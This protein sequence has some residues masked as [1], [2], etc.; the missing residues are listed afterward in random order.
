MTDTIFLV[1]IFAALLHA[2]WNALVKGSQDK[3][4][5]MMGVSLGDLPIK[6]ALLFFVPLPDLSLLPWLLASVV[7]HLGYNLFLVTSYRLGD[8]TQVYP[9][10][11]GSAP[12]LVLIVSV[13][14]LGE[15]SSTGQA[16]GAAIIAIGII[17]LAFVQNQSANYDFR[18]VAAALITG[19]F[20]ASY[21]LV[22]GMG[23]RAAPTAIGFWLWAA[24]GNSIAFSLWAAVFR[25]DLFGKFFGDKRAIGTGIFAGSASF[26]AY[27]IV[28]WAFTQAPIAIVTALRETS[29]IFALLIG[30]GL[31]G[32]RLSL[33][34]VMSTMIT[35][36]G[37]L[38]LRLARF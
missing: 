6:F 38:L 27:A 31:M 14:F 1:V 25:R 36:G 24:I 35:L 5:A 12:L 26:V 3:H 17:S 21:S 16:M 7:L 29:I 19:C 33:L 9:I 37:A 2:V 32:E 30:V 4:L 10:A 34:K 23:A 28:V 13:F 22:D 8:L 11:R 15:I 20:I 18:A